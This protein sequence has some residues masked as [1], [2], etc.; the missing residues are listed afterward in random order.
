MIVH[1]TLLKFIET[2]LRQN[3]T[4]FSSSKLTS[5]KVFAYSK[6]HYVILRRV[7]KDYILSELF[8]HQVWSVHVNNFRLVHIINMKIPRLSLTI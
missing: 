5:W 6:K 8:L 1:R 4:R 2:E 7:L 3:G